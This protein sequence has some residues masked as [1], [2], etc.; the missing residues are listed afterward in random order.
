MSAPILFAID[1]KFRGES[2]SQHGLLAVGVAILHNGYWHRH[3]WNIAP[4]PAQGYSVK[5]WDT[6]WSERPD[7]RKRLETA[8]ICWREWATTFRKFVDEWNAKGDLYIIASSHSDV[9]YIN[10]YLDSC[11]LP[12]MQF[13]IVGKYRHIHD[14][15]SYTR[16]WIGA[17]TKHMWVNDSEIAAKYNITVPLTEGEEHDPSVDAEK[18]LRF[19]LALALARK[20]G[21]TENM[22]K[23]GRGH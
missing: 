3:T 13:D 17:G 10:Y 8:P 15:E 9:E 6:F 22:I 23:I 16:G 18:M 4:M 2:Y 7:L 20:D 14:S 21:H 19:H 12:L 11:K 1:C 5:C